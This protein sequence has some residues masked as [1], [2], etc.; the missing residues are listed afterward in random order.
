MTSVLRVYAAP[1]GNEMTEKTQRETAQI[2]QF[3]VKARAPKATTNAGGRK[4]IELP[5][6]T[7]TVEFG[8]GWYHDAAMQ[9]DAE[10]ARH[11]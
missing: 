2:Y 11:R 9:Q 6:R 8:S 5:V 1:E 3:P 4:V 7:A 10:Q